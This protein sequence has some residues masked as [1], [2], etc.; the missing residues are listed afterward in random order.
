MMFPV[1]PCETITRP[2]CGFENYSIDIYGNVMR[3]G[4]T[5][6]QKVNPSIK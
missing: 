3:K 5:L 4:R 6:K 1:K 2:I